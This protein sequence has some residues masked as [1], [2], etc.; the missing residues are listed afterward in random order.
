MN[1]LITGARGQLGREWV[2][3]LQSQKH[4][5]T[6]CDSAGLDITDLDQIRRMFAR[7]KPDV[8]INCA[9]YTN[10]DGA[11]DH[12]A[13]AFSV[14]A[15]GPELLAAECARNQIKLVH[16]STDYVFEGGAK[17]AGRFSNGYP[18]EHH[19]A[20]INVYGRSKMEGEQAIENS[21]ADWMIVRVSWLCGRYGSNFIKTIRQLAAKKDE[22]HVVN[23]QIGTPSF[24]H[25][26]VEKTLQLV[27]RKKSGIFHIS[28]AGAI[29]WH[30]FACKIVEQS[31]IVVPVREVSSSHFPT[32][33][34]RPSFSVLNTDKIRGLGLKPIDWELGTEQ[35]IHQLNTL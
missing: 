22:L 20:P 13:A 28:S 16:Y 24:C 33:A 29:S 32:V 30:R 23:D 17:D 3:Y 18:E 27:D 7:V 34:Q 1:L 10:V 6:A 26:V 15:K 21:G 19:R 25:D 14:N 11:E 2:H 12:P 8:V 31:G 5:Y 9:A 4:P 35:V